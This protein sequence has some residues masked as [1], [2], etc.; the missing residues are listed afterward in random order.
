MINQ[1]TASVTLSAME[2]K[3]L[4]CL[5]AFFWT[6][7]PNCIRSWR[8][9]LHW[10][11]GPFKDIQLTQCFLHP[12]SG[13]WDD[14]ELFSRSVVAFSLDGLHPFLWFKMMNTKVILGFEPCQETNWI[15]LKLSD[16]AGIWSAWCAFNPM[17]E[18]LEPTYL[19]SS[20]LRR[21]FYVL[22]KYT[23]R[24]G[25]DLHSVACHPSTCGENNKCF[26]WWWHLQN[27]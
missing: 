25:Y 5:G 4:P 10:W 27:V 8:Y 17:S 12:K 2:T 6:A 21:I 7:F 1:F 3:D 13:R 18:T 26:R 9:T 16:F 22:T 11:C 15:W 14:L 20:S 24:I 23:K 19:I